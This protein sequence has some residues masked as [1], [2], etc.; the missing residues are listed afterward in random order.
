MLTNHQ[1]S[2]VPAPRKVFTRVE[3]WQSES[4]QSVELRFIESA[5]FENNTVRKEELFEVCPPLSDNRVPTSI[6][7]IRECCI[8]L[9]LYHQDNV[10]RC[11]CCGRSFCY[12]PD[13]K[14]LVK[15]DNEGE[16]LVCVACAK[17]MNSGLVM[18]LWRKLW[19]MG[20]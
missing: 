16:T 4:G 20:D 7:E 12:S 9:R 19:T 13:C 5:V 1:N 14:G 2:P 18:K 10:R 15:T 8:C 6:Q 17:E 11:P 3:K